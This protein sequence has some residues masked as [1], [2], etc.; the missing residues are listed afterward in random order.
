MRAS[1]TE[2]ANLINCILFLFTI[3]YFTNA[4]NLRSKKFQPGGKLD[5]NK[6]VPLTITSLAAAIYDYNNIPLTSFASV[7]PNIGTDGYYGVD[8]TSA[9]TIGEP[10]M[11]T[12]DNRSTG[13]SISSPNT[14]L[15]RTTNTNF[16]DLPYS[17]PSLIYGPATT[18]IVSSAVG[19]IQ[20]ELMGHYTGTN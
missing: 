11:V 10:R 3:N 12:D 17:D 20:E 19:N 9:S 18:A 2:Q 14:D 4:T 8:V 15:Y 1:L 13:S 7:E 16:D 5:D 6:N